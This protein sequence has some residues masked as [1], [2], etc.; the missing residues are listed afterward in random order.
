MESGIIVTFPAVSWTVIFTITVCFFVNGQI[1]GELH[2]DETA[3]EN[4][5]EPALV[6]K[7]TASEASAGPGEPFALNKD[8]IHTVIDGALTLAVDS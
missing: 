2:M 4:S 5:Q 8:Y 1:N 7:A 3:Q 6:V